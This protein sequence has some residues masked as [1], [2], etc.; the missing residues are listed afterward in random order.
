[1]EQGNK[2]TDSN[3]RTRVAELAA[4]LGM[5]P[6]QNKRLQL[7]PG[8]ELDLVCTQLDTQIFAFYLPAVVEA[9]RM[10]KLTSF[11]GASPAMVGL[12]NLR[13]Q[14]VPI[15]DLRILLGLPH[16]AYDENTPIILIEHEKKKRGLIV[17]S[18]TE[19]IKV[20]SECVEIPSR[21]VSHSDYVVALV[22]GQQGLIM[23]LDHTRLLNFSDNE[24]LDSFLRL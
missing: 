24:G 6:T 23:V 3:L 9:I 8:G 19:V 17:D 2:T 20:P 5:L 21:I 12:L 11:P 7:P 4:E 14:I 10:V 22:R 18:I 15:M 13:R 1:M 16:K